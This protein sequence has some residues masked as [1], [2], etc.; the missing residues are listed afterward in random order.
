[1]SSENL[2]IFVLIDIIFDVKELLFKYKLFIC[3]LFLFGDINILC[4]IEFIEFLL[5]LGLEYIY[6]YYNRKWDDIY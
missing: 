5:M 2:N 1:M 6:F 3:V 4:L